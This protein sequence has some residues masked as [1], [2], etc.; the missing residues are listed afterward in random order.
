MRPGGLVAITGGSARLAKVP[1]GAVGTERCQ[2]GPD[3]RRCAGVARSDCGCH[4]V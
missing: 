2:A 4:P 3:R 1:G